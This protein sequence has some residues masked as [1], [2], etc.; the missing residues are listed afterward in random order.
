MSSNLLKQIEWETLEKCVQ[1]KTSY[2]DSKKQT[3]LI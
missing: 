1:K 2:N 3:L